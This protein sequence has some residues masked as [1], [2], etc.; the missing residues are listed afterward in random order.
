VLAFPFKEADD[1]PQLAREA[2]L[3][4]MQQYM[5]ALLTALQAVHAAGLIHRDV[6]A[7]NFLFR[8]PP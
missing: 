2:T 3:R 4:L 7:A 1:F 5:R 6:K 8:C